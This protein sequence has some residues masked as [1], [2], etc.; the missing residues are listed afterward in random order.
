MRVGIFLQ[1]GYSWPDTKGMATK[2]LIWT[3]KVGCANKGQTILAMRRDG[4]DRIIPN[5]VI[6]MCCVVFF[7]LLTNINI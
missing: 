7:F 3:P 5:P 2:C 4:P 6:E 1:I